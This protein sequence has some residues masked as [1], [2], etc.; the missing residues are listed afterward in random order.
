MRDRESAELRA[1]LGADAANLAALLPELGDGATPTGAARS[2][3]AEERFR[4]FATVA[5]FLSASA[6]TTPLL[7]ILDDLHWAD[8]SSLLL[9]EFLAREAGAARLL[10]SGS[11]RDSEVSAA[12]PLSP[13]LGRLAR[14]SHGLRLP[15]RGLA[16]AEVA[17]VISGIAGAEAAPA[18]SAAIHEATE[19]NPFF[20]G[21]LARF[22]AGGAAL[23]GDGSLRI[24][25]SVREVIGLRL[26]NLSPA[27]N[28]LLTLAAVIGREFPL[29][30]LEQTGE[31]GG[32]Q[33]L[34][35]LEEAEAARIIAPTATLGVYRFAHALIRET[36]YDAIPS[37]R[38]ARLHRQ[39]G[40]ALEQLWGEQPEHLAELAQ[41]YSHA[42]SAED[43]TKA[44]AYA[45]R[46][47]EHAR[48]LLA[49]EENARY[50]ALALRALERATP[51]DRQTRFDLLLELAESSNAAGEY[52]AGQEAVG[53]AVTIARRLE[54][55]AA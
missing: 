14:L 45:R 37:L 3:T 16:E 7:I 34:E 49:N 12:H 4:L 13:T 50:Y 11:Y 32:E 30:A 54:D 19:G 20:A 18:L 44:L 38:R 6:A 24:P 26:E 1:D 31:G 29:R 40:E 10:L 8:T 5:A 25:P 41:H 46:T 9:F 2:E 22:Q 17:A 28:H 52:A 42:A 33:A 21:E 35:A 47:A 39:V 15:L 53:Q 27:C 55:P 48:R 43:A 36:L 51:N 23:A